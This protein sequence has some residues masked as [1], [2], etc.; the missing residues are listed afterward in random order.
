MKGVIT[1]KN[2]GKVYFNAWSMDVKF[3]GENVVRH[4]DLT[5]HNHAS[6]PGQ[7]PTWPYIDAAAFGGTGPCK[8]LAKSLSEKCPKPPKTRGRKSWIKAMCDN[9]DSSCRDAMKCVLSPYDPRAE[10]EDGSVTQGNCCPSK[11]PHH[12]VEVHC[13]APIGNRD[14]VMS[15][16]KNN[17]G[18]GYNQG[19]APCVCVEGPREDK[20]HGAFHAIQQGIEAA[21][22]QR[23]KAP[24]TPMSSGV[25]NWTYSDARDAGVFAQM[26][27]LPDCNPECTKAQLDAY[28][29]APPPDGPGVNDET[30]LRSDT[31]AEGRS[32]GELTSRMQSQ[33]DTRTLFILAAG[34]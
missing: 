17:A 18:K 8:D 24:N 21:Y 31:G 32:I 1:H 25:S 3:E 27:V 10:H 33:L 23:M 16:F 22:N 28:H 5:T 14:G 6:K 2:M 4:L 7:T 34:F 11:T 15:E 29:N 13:F 26:L 20:E 12:L 9:P 19:K 30:P